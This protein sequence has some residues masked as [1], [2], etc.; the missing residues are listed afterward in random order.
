MI[1]SDVIEIPYAEL[2]D[3]I[4]LIVS[5]L[6]YGAFA[7]AV[8]YGLRVF[9]NRTRMRERPEELHPQQQHES[10]GRCGHATA[11]NA[12]HSRRRDRA[13]SQHARG[14]SGGGDAH[15]QA[16][17]GTAEQLRDLGRHRPAVA[18]CHRCLGRRLRCRR[19]GAGQ[20]PDIAA[21]GSPLE[22]GRDRHADFAR[23]KITFGHKMDEVGLEAL[24]GLLPILE[25]VRR[26]AI[27]VLHE[28]KQWAH[29][30]PEGPGAVFYEELNRAW[31]QGAG[32]SRRRT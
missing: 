26:F 9:V 28:A 31:R 22:V 25:A 20:R 21:G 14:A 30:D 3:W 15:A 23:A 16:A 13:N 6:A 4:A 10:P 5:A 8:F 19:A 11:A 17:E 2:A 27:G 32:R 29:E 18:E 1:I 7:M 12:A 24:E